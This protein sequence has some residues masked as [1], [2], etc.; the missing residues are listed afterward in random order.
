VKLALVHDWLNQIGGAEDVLNDLVAMFPDAPI[1]T[2]I[3]APDLMPKQY[4]SWDIRTLWLDKLPA[5]HRHHQ[6]YLPF[7]PLAWGGLDLSEYDVILSNKSG[8]CHGFQWGDKLHICYCLA[9]TRYVW[10]LD[11]YVAR[12]GFGALTQAALKPLIAALRRWDFAAAQRVNHFIAI[13]TDIQDRIRRY[14]QRDSTIIF[15]PVDCSRFQPMPAHEVEDYFLV[16]S[17]LIPYKRIDLAVQAATRL[18]LPLKVGGRGRDLDRLKAIAGPTV[19]FLGY[20]SDE[21][22]PS[23]MAKC[24]AFLFPGLEDFGITPV[25]A[26]AAGRP[27]IAY[28]GGGALDTVIPSVTGEFFDSLANAM[29]TFDATKYDPATIRA[30][31]LKFDTPLFKQQIRDTIESA[32][33][34]HLATRTPRP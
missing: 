9:P 8:F 21:A 17:R 16:V 15:P 25:Q 26:Q 23:L 1:F 4:Q 24:K 34:T 11:S 13:S 7:Y 12:E 31:A 6:P 22:L 14:Y 18:N 20:V 28:K 27:V 19:E 29:A 3:Y 33:R 10:Q 2:S 5:I 32:Y 30:H